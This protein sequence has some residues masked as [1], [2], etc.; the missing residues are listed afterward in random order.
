MSGFGRA[1]CY[2][3]VFQL[4]CARPPLPWVGRISIHHMKGKPDDPLDLDTR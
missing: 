2:A 1:D 3:S 4:A